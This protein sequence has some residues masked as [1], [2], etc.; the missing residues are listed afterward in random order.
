MKGGLLFVS[1]PE[2]KLELRYHIRAKYPVGAIH[3]SPVVSV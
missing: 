2:S 3:E 1:F